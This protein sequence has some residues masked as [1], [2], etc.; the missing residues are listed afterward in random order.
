MLLQCIMF[1]SWLFSLLIRR[2]VGRLPCLHSAGLLWLW[3]MS[4]IWT[5]TNDANTD[6]C[7]LVSTLSTFSYYTLFT[8]LT[9]C[10]ESGILQRPPDTELNRQYEQIKSTKL[11]IDL[12]FSLKDWSSI[13]KS[14]WWSPL[15]YPWVWCVVIVLARSWAGGGQGG[16][17]ESRRVQGVLTPAVDTRQCWQ[18]GQSTWAPRSPR[19]RRPLWT[20]DWTP[21]PSKNCKPTF[22][23]FLV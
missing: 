15:Q 22:M 21:R 10:R 6:H 16:A 1:S 7:Q 4:I 17:G 8:P 13:S 18:R 9:G 20:R 12:S 23:F 19:R 5:M 14:V 3:M 11:N 2:D